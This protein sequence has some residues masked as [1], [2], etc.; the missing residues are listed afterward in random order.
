MGMK[1]LDAILNT[2]SDCRW[3]VD[4][5]LAIAYAKVGNLHYRPVYPFS[6]PKGQC[7]AIYYARAMLKLNNRR[8]Y[9]VDT[10][11]KYDRYRETYLRTYYPELW[12]R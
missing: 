12:E 5:F 7:E 8:E 11:D 9:D 10:I 2:G 6:L 4:H 1:I 3:Y